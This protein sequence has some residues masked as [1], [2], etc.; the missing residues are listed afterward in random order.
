MQ[1]LN[2]TPLIHIG[3]WSLLG[4]KKIEEWKLDEQKQVVIAKYKNGN[5]KD[6]K[7]I[8]VFDNYS[9]DLDQE[10]NFTG[11]L[12]ILQ[13]CEILNFN[14]EQDFKNSD[15]K[16]LAQQQVKFTLKKI[17]DYLTGKS[18]NLAQ[19]QFLLVTFADLKK[20][21]YQYRVISSTLKIDDIKVTKQIQLKQLG[22]TFQIENFDKNLKAYVDNKENKNF[23]PQFVYNSKLGEI[24]SIKQ[25][26][27][28]LIEDKSENQNLYFVIFDPFNQQSANNSVIQNFLA[29]FLRHNELNKEKQIDI[30]QLNLI[31]LK[32]PLLH[33]N[34]KGTEFKYSFYYQLDLS[35]ATIAYEDKEKG[36][37]QHSATKDIE[38]VKEI[39]LKDQMDEIALARDAIDLNVKLM[40]WRMIPNLDFELLKNTKVLLVG[41]GTLGCQLSRNLI[42]WGVQ[43]ITFLDNGKVS[44]SNP[45]RQSLYEF[46][47]TINGGKPKAITAAQK[48]IKIFPE[49]KA[50]GVELQIPMPGHFLVNEEQEKEALKN[51]DILEQLVQEHDAMFL[52]TDSRESRWLPTI[53]ANKYNK[54]CITVGLG[55]DSF[56]IVRHGISSEI[57]LQ[58]EQ[59][60]ALKQSKKE[61]QKEEKKENEQ[62]ISEKKEEKKSIISDRLACY[63]CNDIAVPGNSMRDRTLDQQCTVT[64]PG[65][66][67]VSSAYASELLVSL[68]SHPL[69]IDCPAGEDR[70]QLQQTDLGIVPQHIRGNMSDFETQVYYGKAFNNCIACSDFILQEYN[71]N[72]DEFLL[73]V[74]NDSQFLHQVAEIDFGTFDDNAIIEIGD[75]DNI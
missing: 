14:T 1:F 69:K 72:R 5:L 9:F 67:F 7:S 21:I 48:L 55:F 10:L 17:D 66:S 47:D 61:N 73:R 71:K 13:K 8:L 11:P 74:I 53:L 62:Q 19:N 3:F 51:V 63:F 16:E 36:L 34:P 31:A 59:E 18:E 15:I 54:I 68:L 46:E 52:M 75:D 25:G 50:K 58:R 6:K 2:F 30:S 37:L 57:Q 40:K 44:Y 64:R 56:V 12:E 29:V 32:D 60:E 39:N 22:E 45:V 26:I 35:Q 27:D 43:N 20:Y 65:L 70:E 24:Q 33:N 4:K 28:I 49:I 42:G 23:Y 38:T 41:A